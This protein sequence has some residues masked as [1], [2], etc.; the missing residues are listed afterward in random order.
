MDDEIR[1]DKE[2]WRNLF[3]KNWP[4]LLGIIII[5]VISNFAMT[6]SEKNIE[7]CNDFWRDQIMTKCPA[8]FYSAPALLNSS[9]LDFNF[10]KENDIL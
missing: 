9:P 10:Q 6:A 4:V 7:L 5:L 3:L 8:V 2:Y 1:F